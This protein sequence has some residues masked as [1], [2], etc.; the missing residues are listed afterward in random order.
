MKGSPRIVPTLEA[1]LFGPPEFRREGRLFPPFAT[2]KTT[3][4]LAYLILH[5]SGAHAREQLATLFWGDRDS[6]HAHH[7]LATSLWRIRRLLSRD[8]LLVDSGFIQLNPAHPIWWDVAEFERLTAHMLT[9]E[10]I[11][12]SA[13]S[14]LQAAIGLYRGDLLEGFYDDWCVEERYRL[15]T[16]YLDAL[17][18]LALHCQSVGDAAGTLRYAQTYL[19]RDPLDED[20]Q[21]AT[22]R[23]FSSLGNRAGAQRQWQLY[24]TSRQRDLNKPPSAEMLRQ[25]QQ[26]LGVWAMNPLPIADHKGTTSR[27][28]TDRLERPPFVGRERELN[29][30]LERWSH[31]AEST[32][33]LVL[34]AGEAGAGKTRLI[35]ELAAIVHW[36]GGSVAIG[37]SYEAEQVIPYQPF[38]EM[39][40]GLLAINKADYPRALSKWV[41]REL[42]RLIPEI[43]EQQTGEPESRDAQLLSSAAE[44]IRSTALHAPLLIVL[45]DLQWADVSSL[46]ALEYLS[47]HLGRSPILI[48]GTYRAEEVS[49]SHR[50]AAIAQRL[51]RDGLAQHL[52]LEALTLEEAAELVGALE[53]GGH[54]SAES[55][56]AHTQGNAFFLVETL[57]ELAAMPP[58]RLGTATR[59][60]LPIPSTVRA[61][62]RT[63]LARLREPARRLIS[64]ASVAGETFDLDLSCRAANMSE[65]AALVA[66]DEL[67][68]RG[69]V[70]ESTG[71]S[72]HEYEFVHSLI[73]QV[74]YESLHHRH[75]RFLHRVTGEA[76]EAMYEDRHEE[77]AGLLA[78]HFDRAG[79]SDKTLAFAGRAARR[80]WRLG[81]ANEARQYY[82][83]A[84][85]A[86]QELGEGKFGKQGYCEQHFELLLGREQVLDVLACHEEQAADQDVLMSLAE[87]LDDRMRRA[88]VHLRRFWLHY[89]RHMEVAR[90]EAERALALSE[91][92]GRTSILVQALSA[93]ALAHARLGHPNQGL[94]YAQLALAQARELGDRVLE[95]WGLLQ[96]GFIHKEMGELD[97]AQS[98]L[99][100]S[101]ALNRT[102]GNQF[103]IGRTL[104]HLGDIH[105]T[106]GLPADAEGCYRE[107]LN[108]GQDTGY[109][110]VEEDA[111]A[112]LMWHR[113]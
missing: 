59:K 82:D 63:R 58:D 113:G 101:L 42:A 106:R 92:H 62:I 108:L 75:R 88:Q 91:P 72:G 78:Y 99:E 107:A 85:A 96:V 93:S 56:Y 20:M 81:A 41:R 70:R 76:L 35:E 13:I 55:L 9:P 57:R 77:L 1:F 104:L 111:R 22:M 25:A 68:L 30:L 50:L 52:A 7:S 19:S 64:F 66:L 53:Q 87:S 46:A 15:E 74:V 51:A 27:P 90:A 6:L 31:V 44:L 39:I 33:V 4:L 71:T 89:P 84:L 103:A 37:H 14:D 10:A 8:E 65:E 67:L 48:L 2:R 29:A 109:R 47:R 73:Y 98:V 21:M 32:D 24:C 54:E 94:Q 102:V 12:K 61:L 38:T 86:L 23:A 105:R 17:R 3:S 100:A 28:K 34:I 80:A 110:W 11:R 18:C 5:Q 79:A 112:R 45:E 60:P 95:G 43:G 83:L 40:R 36:R 49:D 16:L 69:F 97:C 26:I